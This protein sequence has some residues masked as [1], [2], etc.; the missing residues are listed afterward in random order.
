MGRL[1][2]LNEPLEPEAPE[3]RRFNVRQLLIILLGVLLLVAFMAGA[4]SLAVFVVMSTTTTTTT[5]TT[6]STSTSASTTATSETTSTSTTSTTTTTT[7]SRT[8]TTTTTTTTTL[9]GGE[10]MLPCL[11]N[12]SC[13][14]GFVENSYGYCV[15]TECG[16]TVKRQDLV[17]GS[18][19]TNLPA[20]WCKPGGSN[21]A[22]RAGL[23][24]RP[25]V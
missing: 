12:R 25:K 8:T 1:K 3:P 21:P 19:N 7:T 11:A 5:T 6:A 18:W 13:D 17:C 9:C 24:Y 4:G 22:N 2:R 15:S 14:G 10:G 20:D 23:R 16:R